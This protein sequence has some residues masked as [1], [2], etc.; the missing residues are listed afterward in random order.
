MEQ[1]LVEIIGVIVVAEAADITG[2]RVQA[3]EG[4]ADGGVRRTAGV[5]ETE[6]AGGGRI[7][8]GIERERGMGGRETG[9]GSETARE[10]GTRGGTGLA[11]SALEKN[12][13]GLLARTVA[14]VTD[15]GAVATVFPGRFSSYF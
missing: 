11:V 13:G 7:I 2:T 5:V 14:I 3:P 12:T 10:R 1:G 8:T 9:R 4:G 6:T 15:S